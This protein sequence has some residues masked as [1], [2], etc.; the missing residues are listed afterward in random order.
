LLNLFKLYW[1]K[2]QTR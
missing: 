2:W 1:P